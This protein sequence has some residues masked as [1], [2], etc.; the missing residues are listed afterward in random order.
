MSVRCI[1]ITQSGKRCKNHT[2]NDNKLCYLHQPLERLRYKGRYIS[3]EFD[4]LV[5]ATARSKKVQPE[6]ILGNPEYHKAIDNLIENNQAT[7]YRRAKNIA[8]ML[9]KTGKKEVTLV[10]P[11]GNEKVSAEEA[12][13]RLVTAEQK[14]RRKKDLVYI[15]PKIVQRIDGE[16]KVHIFDEDASWD[17]IE[18]WLDGDNSEHII[19][20]EE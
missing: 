13:K 17:E 14:I 19:Y 3:E 6:D 18:E 20:E 10:T 5:R 12:I 7:S 15:A 4:E 1:A 2:D 8:K 11:S 9:K 16:L